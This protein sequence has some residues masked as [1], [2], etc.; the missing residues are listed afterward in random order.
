MNNFSK[1]IE[2]YMNQMKMPEIKDEDS[3]R[4]DECFKWPHEKI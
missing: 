3:N 2:N 1:E 4:D